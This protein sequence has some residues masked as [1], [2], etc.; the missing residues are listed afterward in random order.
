ME[1]TTNVNRSKLGGRQVPSDFEQTRFVT[2]YEILKHLRS[3]RLLGVLVIEALIL[4]LISVLTAGQPRAIFNA[5]MTPYAGWAAT[6]VILGATLFAGDAIVSEFQGR[7]G[8]LLFP[9]PIKRTSIFFGKFASAMIVMTLVLVIYYAIA[10]V[11]SSVVS[12]NLDHLELALYS[13]GLALLYALAAVSVGMFISSLLK[14]SVASLVLTFFLLFLIL[15]IV[16]G[17][18]SL[19]SAQPWFSLTFAAQSISNILTYPYPV[20]SSAPVDLGNGQTM[21]IWSHF[22]DLGGAIAVML[23]Y[24]IVLSILTI[25]F[26]RRREMTG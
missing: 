8:Y 11:V 5:A 17:L 4:V 1:A 10:I 26:F 24:T 12:N 3:R 13:F 23:I 14:S 9:N 18:F 22:P 16:D 6:L 2:K 21:T 15:P 19:T 25:F 20:D 7:T